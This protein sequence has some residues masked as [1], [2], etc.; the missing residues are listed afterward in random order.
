L[1]E[2]ILLKI[3]KNIKITTAIMNLITK[4]KEV[5]ISIIKHSI[6]ISKIKI[7][8]YGEEEKEICKFLECNPVVVIKW[9]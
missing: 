2:I 8:K 4:L 9:E 1:Y 3:N 6:E 5:E 7:G